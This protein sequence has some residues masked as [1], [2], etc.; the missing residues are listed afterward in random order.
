[1][2]GNILKCGYVSNLNKAI[3]SGDFKDVIRISEALHEKKI[4]QIADYIKN[5]IEQIKIILIAGPS[6]SGKLPSLGG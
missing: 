6:S 4:A 1:M 3:L 5:N 2:G